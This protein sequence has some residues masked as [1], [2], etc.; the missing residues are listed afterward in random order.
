M[1]FERFAFT[2]LKYRVAGGFAVLLLLFLALIVAHFVV[3]EREREQQESHATRIDV[4]RDDNRAVLQYMTDAE[5]GIRGFQLTGDPAF[6]EPYTSGRAG[7][8]SAMDRLAGD[9][10]DAETARLLLAERQAAEGWLYGYAIPIVNAGEPDTDAG[11]AARGKDLFDRLRTANADVFAAVESFERRV[12][13]DERAVATYSTLLFAGLAALVVAAGLGLALLH[14]RHLLVPLEHIRLT[15]RRLA[16]GD[17]SARATPAGPGE[18]R[19]V[20]GTL[21]DLAARTEQLISAERA[22]VA[23]SELRQAV[24][25][26][27]QEDGEPLDMAWRIAEMI[28]TTL[29][30]EAVHSRITIQA[31]VPI[32]TTW[33]RDAEP[34]DPSIAEQARSCAPGGSLRPAGLPGGLVIPLSGD[35]GCP[36][37]MICLIRPDRPAW[38]EEERRLLIGLGREIDHAA[39]QERLRLRQAR[40]INEL[41]V[42]DEQKDVF[43]ATVTHELRTPLTSILGYSE[44]LVEDE[45]HVIGL[46]LVQKRGVEAILRNA[47][48]LEATV[49]DLLLL[50]RSNER[51]GDSEAVPVD[52]AR[53]VGEVHGTLG[54]AARAKDLECELSTEPAWVR[55]DSAQLE[56][57]V[58]NLLDNA[59]KFTAPG[60]H[61]ECRLTCAGDRAVVTVTDTGIGIPA[62]DVP[63][64]FTPFHRAAN[65]MDQAVQGNGLGLAIVRNIVNDHGGTVTAHSELGRGSTFTMALPRIAA[66]PSRSGRG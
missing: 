5:T 62:D 42:L 45:E 34:L 43:V 12:G 61:L 33:P 19:A 24:T 7:A 54:T 17:L 31:G 65:A 51:I 1:I 36:P 52:L 38:S 4:A 46:S 20:V 37:G 30:A 55:G 56:R 14:Q 57:A 6:L 13:D 39:H 18:L 49:A 29:G 32:E 9:P 35:A 47:H 16:D 25:V 22:R 50:D 2:R 27:L 15:L 21:N 3:S 53:L 60:G 10:L 8:F 26:Q 28:G 58:R 66:M 40:L 44:M 11:R 48:R 41:R 63:G 59:V 23:R 64:L